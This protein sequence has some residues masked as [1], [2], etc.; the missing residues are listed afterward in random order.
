M[1]VLPGSLAQSSPE[2]FQAECI[3]ALSSA[4][5][6]AFDG[7]FT[8]DAATSFLDSESHFFYEDP[9]QVYN[10]GGVGVWPN[11]VREHLPGVIAIQDALH[12][13]LSGGI[14]FEY[15]LRKRS[16][17]VFTDDS[18]HIDTALCRLDSL[19]YGESR[20]GVRL[21]YQL[22]GPNAAVRTYRDDKDVDDTRIVDESHVITSGDGWAIPQD[23]L[24]GMP[25]IVN[26]KTHF[27]D[28]PI[29]SG[30]TPGDRTILI[31][32]AILSP[33][34]AFILRKS[35]ATIRDNVAPRL[36]R[37]EDGVKNSPIL[38]EK[39]LKQIANVRRTYN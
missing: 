22:D 14:Y 39:L 20:P 29:H 33:G 6:C 38:Y 4:R 9:D 7:V 3:E 8:P 16:P 24:I 31:Q 37:A 21:V 13:G 11:V 15:T 5:S 36:G 34:T 30:E 1:H 35:L 12:S 2:M 10:N 19:Q 26:G 32:D 17:E 28:H 23:R 27:I 25:V 18:E